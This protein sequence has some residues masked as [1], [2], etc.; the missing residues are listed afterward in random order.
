MSI[1]LAKKFNGEVVSA[2][3]RQVYKGMDI[4]TGKITK[5]GRKGIPHYLLD[6][7]SPKKIFSVSQYQKLAMQAIKKIQGKNRIPFLIGGTGFYIQSVVDGIIIPKVKPDWKLREK[8]EKETA[9]KLF[10]K[11]E[12]L[13]LRRA[14]NIDKN[15]KR[16]LIRAIEIAMKTKK[17]VPLLEKKQPPFE[18]LIIGVRINP[19]ELKK[20]IKKRLLKRLRN[21]MINEVEKLHKQG[22]SWKRLEEFGLEYRHIAL[23]LQKKITL[24]AT[25]CKRA[26]S[27]SR[28]ATRNVAGEAKQKMIEKI[29]KESEHYAKRQ[30][31]WFKR[32]K[33]I[34]WIKNPKQTEKLVKNFLKK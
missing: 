28:I 18:A 4:G 17:P 3:S 2:D 1:K 13:D 6:V 27:P 29:Q 31:T 12:K 9:E 23:Y 7:A 22:V 8:L 14:E 26:Y 21:G 19:E 30:M 34:Y 25:L 5:K 32:D 16:R 11:L 24:P 20:M 15:N 33:R 10:L